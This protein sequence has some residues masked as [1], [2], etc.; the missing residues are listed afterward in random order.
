MYKQDFEHIAMTAITAVHEND[1]EKAKRCLVQLTTIIEAEEEYTNT[2]ND[3][4]AFGA[5]INYRPY[6]FNTEIRD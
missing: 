6:V 1:L 4:K 3:A 2:I 5:N